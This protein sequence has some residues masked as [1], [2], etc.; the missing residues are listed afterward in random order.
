M[1]HRFKALRRAE[2]FWLLLLGLFTTPAA[3]GFN[4]LKPIND[5]PAAPDFQLNDLQ[6]VPHRL[7]E[8][9]GKVVLV[10]FWATWCPP[11]RSEMPSL[12][13]AWE[14][15]KS[16]DFLMFGVS[17]SEDKYTVAQFFYTM[18]T[19][20]TFPVLLDKEMQATRFW[21]IRGLPATFIVDKQGRVAYIMHGALEWDSPD[22]IRR[23]ETLLKEP[24]PE[25]RS[26]MQQPAHGDHSG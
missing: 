24:A 4:T 13:R 19:P 16:N 8:L 26:A 22:V 18:T 10:N 20:P 3:L 1:G 6:G 7:S 17:V 15:L 12:Q 14:R 23:I 11:C 5:R 21:P 2:L 25:Q 9:R